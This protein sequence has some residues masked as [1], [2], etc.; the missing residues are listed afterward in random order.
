M[1]IDAHG[2]VLAP[3]EIYYEKAILL[4]ERC[5]GVLDHFPDAEAIHRSVE[6]HVGFLDSVGTD[7]QL[8]APRPYH[9]MHAERPAGVVHHWIRLYNDVI[10]LQCVQRPDRLRG[11]AGLPQVAGESP[12]VCIPELDRIAASGEFVGVLVN[13]DPGEGDGR[14]PGLGDEYWYPLWQRLCD[15]DLPAL[16]V[17][18]GCRNAREGYNV[19][20]INEATTAVLSLLENPRLFRDFPSLR[21]VIGYGGGAI[22]YQAGRWRA[23]RWG[24]QQYRP[25][26]RFEDFDVGLRRLW[27]DTAVYGRESIEM[28]L[29]VCGVDRCLFGTQRPGGSSYLDP[30]TGRSLDD[31]K[32]VVESIEWL[33]AAQRQALFCGNALTVFPRLAAT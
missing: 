3:M 7:L 11:I 13:P 21:L 18:G 16:V 1:I 4:G 6:R 9:L 12:S 28:L 23:R 2:Y 33:D 29:R 10:R 19:H 32:P 8:V 14:T 5:W 22:P 30:R 15:H 31:L 20:Y 17:S 24:Q 25:E 26:A 27:F